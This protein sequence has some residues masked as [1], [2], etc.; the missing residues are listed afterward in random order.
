[1]KP[2]NLMKGSYIDETL[3]KHGYYLQINNQNCHYEIRVNDLESAIYKKQEP[4]MSVRVP[5]NLEISKS[6]TQ[7]LSIRVFPIKGAFLSKMADLSIGLFY[8]TD[9]S[10]EENSYGELVHLLDWELPKIENEETPMVRLDTVF[11]ATVPYEIKDLDYAL[12]L[13]N[14][15][16]EELLKEAEEKY[17]EIRYYVLNDYDKLNILQT[18]RPRG[19]TFYLSEKKILQVLE[20][21]KKSYQNPAEIKYIQKIENFELAL[22]AYGKIL[23]LKRIEDGSNVICKAEILE[24]DHPP[25]YKKGDINIYSSLPIYLYKDKRDNQWHIW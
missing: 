16:K 25:Y 11:K 13:S 2:I 24:E 10:D 6:G 12:D 8:Y 18:D 7:S 22:Y 5:I 15:D 23:A 9:M 4:V 20:N 17:K 14:M 21:N 1:M 3:P 19:I